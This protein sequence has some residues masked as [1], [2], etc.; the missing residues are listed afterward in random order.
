M[1]S[2]MTIPMS[3]AAGNAGQNFVL[4]RDEEPENDEQFID[5]HALVNIIWRNLWLIGAIVVAAILLAI[6]TTFLITPKYEAVSSVQ[7]DQEAIKVLD[8]VDVEPVASTQDAARFLQTNVDVLKSRGTTERVARALQLYDDKAFLKRMHAK[9][10]EIAVPGRTLDQMRRDAVIQVLEKGLSINLPRDSR[11]VEIRFASADPALAA[12]VANSYATN[13]IES[14]LQRK[15]EST[16]YARKFLEDQ[17]GQAKLRLEDS[18]RQMVEYARRAGLIDV[19]G[20][21]SQVV[22]KTTGS[23]ET[24]NLIALNESYAAAKAARIAAEER[25]RTAQN[26][27]ANSMPEVIGNPAVQQMLVTRAQKQ[28]ELMNELRQRKADHPAVV[29]AKAEVAELDRQLTA[30]ASSVRTGIQ[31]QYYAA[32]RQEQSLAA[33]VLTSK[34]SALDERS[35]AIEYT[36]L[37]REVDT[38]RTL[39]DGLLQRYKEVSAAAGVTTNNISVVDTAAVPTEPSSPRLV[40]NVALGALCGLAAA[41]GVVLLREK[42]DDRVRQPDDLERKLDLLS[43]GVIPRHG[44]NETPDSALRSKYSPMSEA[45][46]SLVATLSLS[47]A[48]GFPKIFCVTSAT[49][50]EGKTTSAIAIAMRLAGQ[51]KNVLLVDAD[52]RRP[53]VHARLGGANR[54]GFSNCLAGQLM[55]SQVIHRFE[56]EGFSWMASGPIPPDPAQLLGSGRLETLLLEFSGSYDV[57]ILDSPPVLGLA[58][59]LILSAGADSTLFVVESG[60]GHFGGVKIALRRLRQA[61]ANIVGGLLTK[62]DSKKFLAGRYDYYNGYYGEAGGISRAAA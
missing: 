10:P 58:D 47:S 49:A 2:R 43:V 16:S 56:R 31:N 32:Q 15:F 21:G 33:Q 38:N 7:I 50:R 53:T 19:A 30:I 37:S 3:E 55:P 51:G 59:A 9:E 42:F 1:A 24:D 41:A 8:T 39:Y 46:A 13:F 25:W 29:R 18:E 45:Y 28:A 57:I 48:Q 11:V 12:R 61:H 44:A 14:N 34:D 52:L 20:S 27:P 26:A 23:I 4:V 6:G 17:L 54:S 60:R 36:I 5:L 22:A 40:L 35:R 62:Y